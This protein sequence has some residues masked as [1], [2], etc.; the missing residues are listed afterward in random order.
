MQLKSTKGRRW[1]MFVPCDPL[2]YSILIYVV[3]SVILS[4]NISSNFESCD[5]DKKGCLM[6]HVAGLFHF[7]CVDTL[8]FFCSFFSGK[9]CF[10][11]F[12]PNEKT[13]WV[14]YIPRTAT[15]TIFFLSFFLFKPLNV[16]I[17][18]TLWQG[19]S[20]NVLQVFQNHIICLSVRICE[21]L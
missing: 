17:V 14:Y 16:L 18:V 13:V 7:H 5:D 12:G 10:I 11:S 2:K 3:S 21:T 9:A 4:L 6:K 20:P 15:N 8:A 19:I 1:D